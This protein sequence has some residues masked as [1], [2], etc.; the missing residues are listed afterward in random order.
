MKTNITEL[1]F[2]LDR[3]G[4]M[5]GLEADTIGGYNALLKKQT[6]EQ[7]KA[8]VTTVLFDDQYEILHDRE[9]IKLVTPITSEEYYVRG[10]TALLDAIGKTIQR[11]SQAQNEMVAKNKANQ[12]I[13]VITTDGLENASIEYTS[14]KVKALIEKHRE[15]HGWEFI[16]LGAN[17][18]AV[19][20]A[21]EFGI[22][23]NRAANFHADSKG[24]QKNF[25]I[26]DEA[27]SNM[28]ANKSLA[29]DWK[30]EIDE[31]FNTRKI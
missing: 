14:K 22:K 23:E 28:R 4:S 12:I 1:V 30:E 2:I 9:A 18:D 25:M 29:D 13:F 27:I 20:T 31:D 19:E 15:Q 26:L 7:G 10:S 21:R 5:Q 8:F 11:V 17:I 24:I 6:K 3:S 16:F